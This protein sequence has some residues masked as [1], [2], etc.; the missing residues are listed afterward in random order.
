[1]DQSSGSESSQ[2]STDPAEALKIAQEQITKQSNDLKDTAKSLSSQAIEIETQRTQLTLD[3]E[4]HAKLEAQFRQQ[5]DDIRRAQDE[6]TK[7]L[8]TRRTILD[9]EKA[10]L[11]QQQLELKSSR[12]AHEGAET[13]LVQRQNH[14]EKSLREHDQVRTKLQQEQTALDSEKSAFEGE[15]SRFLKEQQGKKQAIEAQENQLKDATDAHERQKLDHAQREDALLEKQK[16]LEG[17]F[18]RLQKAELD[19]NAARAK[20]NAEDVPYGKYFCIYGSMLLLAMLLPYYHHKKQVSYVMNAE[21]MLEYQRSDAM[22]R[23]LRRAR[24]TAVDA[25][26][27]TVV[28]PLNPPEPI[29]VFTS[30]DAGKPARTANNGAGRRQ[31]APVVEPAAPVVEP[32]AP[33]VEPAA[34]PVVNTAHRRQPKRERSPSPPVALKRKAL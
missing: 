27:E 9:Q 1:M 4:A 12:T 15:Q 21:Q 23:T 5:Q 33:V 24:E 16:K 11:G 14:L 18:Q 13:Q 10:E 2:T 32:A 28:L 31:A 34:D 8:D 7:A 20:A 17:D 22:A 19:F 6:Q 29:P 26:P 30:R 3:Q 25:V